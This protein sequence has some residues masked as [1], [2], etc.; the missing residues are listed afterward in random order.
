VRL[1]PLAVRK[2]RLTAQA[3]RKQ[4][5]IKPEAEELLEE[6]MQ[7]LEAMDGQ[8]PFELLGLT[9]ETTAVDVRKAYMQLVKRLHPDRLT[10]LGLGEL[11]EAAD[12]LFKRITEA[13]QALSNPEQLEDARRIYQEA[14]SG[15]D[16]EEATRAIEAEV[17]FQKGEVYFRKGSMAEAVEHFQRAVEGN[18]AEGEHHVML[19]WARYQQAPPQGRAEIRA[20]TLEALYDGLEKSPRCARGHYFVGKLHLEDKNVDSALEAFRKA[21]RLKRNYIEAMREIRLIEMRQRREGSSRNRS[22]LLE[23]FTR[24]KK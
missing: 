4:G 13:H 8:S 3:I 1:P 23:M 14:E 6:V 19:A 15:A 18:P 5:Q 20:K 17:D 2:A 7:R 24:K 10:A 9:L 12:T 16:P 11:Y 22:T 21:S